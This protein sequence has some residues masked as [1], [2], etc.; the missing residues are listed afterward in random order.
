MNQPGFQLMCGWHQF[1][2]KLGIA[3]TNGVN[4]RNIAVI[5]PTAGFRSKEHPSCLHLKGPKIIDPLWSKPFRQGAIF[6]IFGTFVI[7]PSKSRRPHVFVTGWHVFVT[8]GLSRE[9]L[10]GTPLANGTGSAPGPGG[11]QRSE[12]P[13]EDHFML[14]KNAVFCCWSKRLLIGSNKT[15]LVL[16]L[17]KRAIFFVV[18]LAHNLW[19]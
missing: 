9:I 15:I 5:N 19:L 18:S 17:F 8:V 1:S 6:K 10:A 3:P 13:S 11:S 2:C 12:L 16:L 7:S 14:R 4:M